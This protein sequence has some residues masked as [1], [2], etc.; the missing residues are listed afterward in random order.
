[1][2]IHTIALLA[3]FY[4]ALSAIT[5]AE[6]AS[7]YDVVIVGAGIS[8]LKAAETLYRHDRNI[9]ILILEAH[10]YIGGRILT[11]FDKDI[12]EAINLG[13]AYIHGAGF[14]GS[15]HPLNTTNTQ[16]H[17]N[18]LLRYFSNKS[19]LKVFDLFLP[20]SGYLTPEYN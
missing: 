16:R 11:V 8:G 7:H 20:T 13:A 2:G 14:H 6:K 9:K 5:S 1:M 18:P 17:L 10:A 3:V 19:L 4:V 12:R 15:E